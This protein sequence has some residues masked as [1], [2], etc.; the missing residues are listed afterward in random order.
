MEGGGLMKN[1]KSKAGVIGIIAMGI[2]LVANMVSDWSD[3]Q[4]LNEEIDARVE[5]KF[6]ELS[7]KEES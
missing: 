6:K 7:M 2:G 1:I 3:E 5:E 4:K